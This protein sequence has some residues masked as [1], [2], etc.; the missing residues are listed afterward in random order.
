MAILSLSNFL[1][2]QNVEFKISNFRSAK[3]GFRAAQEDIKIADDFREK[4]LLNFLNMQDAYIEAENA[5][6]HYKK[7]YDFNPNNAEL[8]YKISSVLLF[9]NRKEFARPLATACQYAWENV[10]SGNVD[11]CNTL[12]SLQ[13]VKALCVW[14]RV[15]VR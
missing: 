12:E 2:A 3:K 11:F 5:Y 1:L 10:P 15:C 6:L 4:A 13:S 8:N 14:L 7:A 9:T